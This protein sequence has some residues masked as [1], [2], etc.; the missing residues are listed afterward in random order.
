MSGSPLCRLCLNACSTFR[1]LYTEDGH[2]TNVYDTTI[3]Y[4]EPRVIIGRKTS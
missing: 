3:K 1:K 4:F 2:F